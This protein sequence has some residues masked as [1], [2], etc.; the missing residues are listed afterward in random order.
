MMLETKPL[1][2]ITQDALQVLYREIGIVNTVRF[3]NQFSTGFGDYTEEREKLFG[4]LT[5]DEVIAEIKR[6]QKKD[7]A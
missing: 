3:L 1:A 2:E 6:G 7:A 5:L 4:H